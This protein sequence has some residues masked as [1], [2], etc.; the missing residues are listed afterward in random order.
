[1]ISPHSPSHHLLPAI[2]EIHEHRRAK[3]TSTPIGEQA[4]TQKSTKATLPCPRPGMPMCLRKGRQSWRQE[5][6]YL[7]MEC[8]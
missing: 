2:S 7:D 3:A 4:L 1:M 5:G 6:G 8:T